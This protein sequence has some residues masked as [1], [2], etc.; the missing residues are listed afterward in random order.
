MCFL[1]VSLVFCLMRPP[2][3]SSSIVV[4]PVQGDSVILEFLSENTAHQGPHRH[5]HCVTQ[6]PCMF[7]ACGRK[8]ENLEQSFTTIV[9]T[10]THGSRRNAD[11]QPITMYNKNTQR[12][13][14]TADILN[15]ILRTV[16][17]TPKWVKIKAFIFLTMLLVSYYLYG[18]LLPLLKHPESLNLC[19]EVWESTLSALLLFEGFQDV[20]LVGNTLEYTDT[21]KRILHG[22]GVFYTKDAA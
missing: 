21:L 13:T 9:R 2:I 8:P 16:W 22:L 1:S 10:H 20:L 19:K 15:V 11:P 7:L 3:Y 4:C 6:V 12:N 5:T 17:L 14:S 18:E